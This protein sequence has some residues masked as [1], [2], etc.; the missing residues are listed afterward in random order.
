MMP[1][2]EVIRTPEEAGQ[3]LARWCIGLPEPLFLE[4]LATV[5]GE[6]EG[7]LM[8][9]GNERAVSCRL[10]GMVRVSACREWQRLQARFHAKAGTA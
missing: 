2:P 8:K 5:A 4:S 10:A 7:A 9:A 6:I 1:S 3:T